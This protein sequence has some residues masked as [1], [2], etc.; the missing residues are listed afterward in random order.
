M[1][2]IFTYYYQSHKYDWRH[3]DDTDTKIQLYRIVGLGRLSWCRN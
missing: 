1:R 2:Y 3:D